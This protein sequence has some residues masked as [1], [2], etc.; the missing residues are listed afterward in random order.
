M[1]R[2]AARAAYYLIRR[3]LP[4]YSIPGYRVT[5]KVRYFL[6]KHMFEFMGQNVLIKRNAYFEMAQKYALVTIHK[7]VLIQ[8][9]I[10]ML[11]LVMM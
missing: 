6:C 5:Y 11:L 2:G 3:F 8:L 7:L 1:G 4:K 9:W 10:T